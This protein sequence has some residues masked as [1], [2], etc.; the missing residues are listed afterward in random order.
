[1]L[2][3]STIGKKIVKYYK[4]SENTKKKPYDIGDGIKIYADFL[5]PRSWDLILGKNVE[6]EVKKAFL[7]NIKENDTVFDCGASIGEFSLIAAKK[8]GS[9]GKVFS[10][11]PFKKAAILLRQNFQL[12][13]FQNFTIIEKAISDK[14]G[15][16]LL[17]ENPVSGTGVLDTT[18]TKR[19]LNDASEVIVTTIDDTI[20]SFNI[21][22]INMLKIDVE[23]FEFEVLKGCKNSFNNKKI[24]NIIIEI[25]L[26]F[27]KKKNLDEKII[28]DFLRDNGYDIKVLDTPDELNHAF[29]IIAK[30]IKP[31]L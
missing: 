22:K 4:E 2:A 21:E 31:S 5:T 25:H 26:D 18:I 10:I 15:K 9:N 1:M 24:S 3:Y 7:N 19:K 29:H 30:L 11:E 6:A 12:N 28:Y 14:P 17:Y 23:G 16:T 8:V 13:N 27:L 20:S